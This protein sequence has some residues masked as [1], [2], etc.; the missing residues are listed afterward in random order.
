MTNR[1]IAIT[2]GLLVLAGSSWS[3][4]HFA[5]PTV[6]PAL[7]QHGEVVNCSVSTPQVPL[8]EPFQGAVDGAPRVFSQY[9]AEISP[10]ATFV[11][12]GL[13]LSRKRYRDRMGHLSPI[14]LA[15]GWQ[16][17]SI[18]G[19]LG[20]AEIKQGRRWYYVTWRAG[21]LPIPPREIMDSS[22]NVH[23]I[24]SSEG[25]SDQIMAIEAGDR[26][27]LAGWLVNVNDRGRQFTWNTSL[28]RNDTGDGSCE[29][30]YV[31]EVAKIPEAR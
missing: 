1:G 10:K 9:G 6:P 31:C 16:R 21:A 4:H 7:T 22:A 29:I 18:P 27:R 24:P 11:V 30:L 8:L 12:D 2:F 17:M 15:I 3:I 23:I 26:V 20:D 14:D 28:T 13:I 25:V 19:V 5:T